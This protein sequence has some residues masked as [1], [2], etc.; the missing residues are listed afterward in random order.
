MTVAPP[1]FVSGLAR[2][3]G[4][5]HSK[6]MDEP[7]CMLHDERHRQ[8]EACLMKNSN[9]LTCLH[10]SLSHLGGNNTPGP[11]SKTDTRNQC[12]RNTLAWRYWMIPKIPTN[13]LATDANGRS[14]RQV[15]LRIIR[16]PVRRG[17]GTGTITTESTRPPV[18]SQFATPAAPSAN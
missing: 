16:F 14:S 4:C 6:F 8:V 17:T 10:C 5:D 3:S 15:L 9:A 1:L 11:P 12:H 7:A 13:P 18:R 2:F